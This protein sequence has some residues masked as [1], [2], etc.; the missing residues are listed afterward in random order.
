MEVVRRSLDAY[1]RRDIKT[2]REVADPHVEL[3][4]SVSL[5]ELAGG[6]RGI[7][8]TLRFYTEWYATFE[9]SV[10]EPER[11]MEVDD[12]VIVPNIA[13]HRGREEIEV[14]ARSALVFTMRNRPIT[15]IRLYQ[16]TSEALKAAG[17]AE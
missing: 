12:L 1:R 3:D 6:Y 5:G 9:M 13:R 16:E 11:F 7:D 10:I 17:L 14:S 4:W 2:L 8:E 15:H